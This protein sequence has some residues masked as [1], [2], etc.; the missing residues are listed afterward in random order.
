MDEIKELKEFKGL[1]NHLS[2][3]F[4]QTVE[5]MNSIDVDNNVMR[6]VI[7]VDSILKQTGE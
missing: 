2:T 5:L 3:D 7:V 6:G 4:A 1:V